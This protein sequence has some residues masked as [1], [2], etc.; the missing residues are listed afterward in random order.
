LGLASHYGQICLLNRKSTGGPIAT[1][2]PLAD[3]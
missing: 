1:E 3:L 2:G